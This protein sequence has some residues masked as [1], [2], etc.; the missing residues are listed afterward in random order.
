[1]CEGRLLQLN[2]KFLE[3]E[4][5]DSTA[6]GIALMKRILWMLGHRLR[7][8]RTRL[9]ASRYDE[10]VLAVKSLIDQSIENLH[11]DSPLLK[12]PYYLE[13]RLTVADAFH[14]LNLIKAHGD[15]TERHLAELC[16]ELLDNVHRELRF[17][18][19][20]QTVYEHIANAP[21]EAHPNLL[22]LRC[23]REFIA[24][25]K[26]LDYRIV[27]E[28][29]LPPTS[30]HIFIMNHL[31]SHPNNALP[32]NFK[33]I[34]DT[35][36]VSSMI[37]HR[38]YGEPPIRVVRGAHPDEIGQKAYYE[39]LGYIM[40][41]P[42]GHPRDPAVK[43]GKVRGRFLAEAEAHLTEGKNLVICP[44]GACT[45]TEQSP[46]AFKSGAFD[47]AADA[48]PEPLIVPIAIANFDKKVTRTRVVAVIHQPFRLSEKLPR[49][50]DPRQLRIFVGEYRETFRGYIHEARQIAVGESQ[51]G[52]LDDAQP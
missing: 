31:C 40:I 39:R 45:T 26:E 30:G 24:M 1:M 50:V 17:Y 41:P 13:N 2:R 35:H 18:T 33:I 34:L 28:E 11:M 27:G 22:R 49:P 29:N 32:N 5:T 48:D 46:L 20:L 6:L 52:N 9:I 37:L 4:A 16:L 15:D 42:Q 14:C 10:E 8:I 3:G 38:K 51:S 12:I 7:A 25:F 19:G 36:F 43:P 21:A 23:S 44:E 47:L